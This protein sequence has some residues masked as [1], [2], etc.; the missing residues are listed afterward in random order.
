MKGY[1][2]GRVTDEQELSG[3]KGRARQVREGVLGIQ[4]QEREKRKE[5]KEEEER[6]E[7]NQS[8]GQ[9]KGN[10]HQCL[11]RGLG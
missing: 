4:A 11:C 6:K 9:E 2:L 5:E 8:N 3:H 7:G 10:D 1:L